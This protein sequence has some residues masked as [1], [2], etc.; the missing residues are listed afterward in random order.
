MS[1][2]P[3]DYPASSGIP[4]YIEVVS[5]SY[6]QIHAQSGLTSQYEVHILIEGLGSGAVTSGK[7]LIQT[8]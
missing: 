6:I 7:I 5:S 3:I 1:G 8:I 4:T 2:S